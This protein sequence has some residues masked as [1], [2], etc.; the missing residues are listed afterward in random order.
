MKT[1]GSWS[2]T[3]RIN[4]ENNKAVSCDVVLHL[5]HY[6]SQEVVEAV[7]CL[8]LGSGNVG[9]DFV[10]EGAFYAVGADCGYY[11]VVVAAGL[12]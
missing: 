3:D 7:D 4:A 2:R 5:C 9:G 8:L 1:M 11:V 6:I 12:D 10:G